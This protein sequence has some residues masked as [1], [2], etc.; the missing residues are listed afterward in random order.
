LSG[1]TFSNQNWA[2]CTEV[3]KTPAGSE[4]KL[5]LIRVHDFLV[6]KDKLEK[7]NA[8][9]LAKESLVGSMP[10]VVASNKI[11]DANDAV[12]TFLIMTQSSSRVV[13]D[14]Y[15]RNMLQKVA[16]AGSEYKVPDRHQFGMMNSTNRVAG[17]EPK[18]GDTL[19]RVLLKAKK[20]KSET[21]A[22]T[23]YII[24]Y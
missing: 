19:A 21:L 13:S 12:Q 8:A 22:G 18:M 10:R 20:G 14:K 24:F 3:H 11:L 7:Q 17:T 15:F 4:V 23:V 6:K 16:G 1:K 9:K 5:K 2:C